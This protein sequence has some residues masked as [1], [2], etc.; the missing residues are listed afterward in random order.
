MLKEW[1]QRF[2]K[3]DSSNRKSEVLKGKVQ[4]ERTDSTAVDD[5]K[6]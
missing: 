2:Q 4:M 6:Q 1:L 3:N 5:K